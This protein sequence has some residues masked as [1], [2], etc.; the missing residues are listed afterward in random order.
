MFNTEVE[1]ENKFCR[2]Y[3]RFVVPVPVHNISQPPNNSSLGN[4]IAIQQNI[5]PIAGLIQKSKY[6]DTG[7]IFIFF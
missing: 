7:T 2:W 5:F 6:V 4:P 1:E 3:H